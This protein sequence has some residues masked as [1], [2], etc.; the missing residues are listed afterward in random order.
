MTDEVNDAV[1]VPVPGPSAPVSAAACVVAPGAMFAPDWSQGMY[2][3]GPSCSTSC[4]ITASSC[5]MTRDH[6][7]DAV[8][9]A[10]PYRVSV[11][12]PKSMSSVY[13]ENSTL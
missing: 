3:T 12:H 1:V 8:I 2:C 13:P 9:D 10:Y 7:S 4:R 5:W 6:A 11:S